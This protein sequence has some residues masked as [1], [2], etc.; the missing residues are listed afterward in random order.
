VKAD[1]PFLARHITAFIQS[2]PDVLLCNRRS[3][4]RGIAPLAWRCEKFQRNKYLGIDPKN[5]WFPQEIHVPPTVKYYGK[6][7]GVRL[8]ADGIYPI[9]T[10]VDIHLEFGRQLNVANLT[11]KEFS[12]I[13][14]SQRYAKYTY[15]IIKLK[16]ED[17]DKVNSCLLNEITESVTFQA[18]ARMLRS[19]RQW[20]KHQRE[21]GSA[22]NIFPL[23]VKPDFV[24]E[25]FVEFLANTM[26]NLDLELFLRGSDIFDNLEKDLTKEVNR[27]H[28][29]QTIQS[30]HVEKGSKRRS[31]EMEKA[32][33]SR[34]LSWRR[35]GREKK[36]P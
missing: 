24:K 36:A 26:A 34:D 10:R 20:R 3:L 13:K 19:L 14:K 15:P 28:L 32:E 23:N 17:V 2:L 21:F 6:P 11:E 25:S 29:E 30:E 5:S 1:V 31:W 18:P 22:P 7:D 16:K 9:W 35:C 33:Q 12:D 4:S 8:L 27:T